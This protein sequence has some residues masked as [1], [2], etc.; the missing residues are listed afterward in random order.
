MNRGRCLGGRGSVGNR[1]GEFCFRPKSPTLKDFLDHS[2]NKILPQEIARCPTCCNSLPFR[3]VL[4]SMILLRR[5]TRL[6][7]PTEGGDHEVAQSV[8]RP[9]AAVLFVQRFYQGM[10]IDLPIGNPAR[11]IRFGLSGAARERLELPA[12]G[13]S[14]KAKV[15]L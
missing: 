11:L 13:I 6:F 7:L 15:F 8:T 4:V 9:L 5:S 10:G 14:E 2:R 3:T 12:S 1:P